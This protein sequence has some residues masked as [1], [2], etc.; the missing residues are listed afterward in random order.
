MDRK[1]SSPRDAELSTLGWTRRF[2]AGSP[3][4][5]EAVE[6]YQALGFEV[7]LE[8]VDTRPGAGC[9][10]CIAENPDLVKVIYTRP[11]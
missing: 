8:P 11:A 4:L 6:Q 2:S 7:L 10:T 1:P 3:R 9:T 5:E